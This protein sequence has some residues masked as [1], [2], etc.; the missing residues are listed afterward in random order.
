MDADLKLAVIDSS[1]HTKEI[2]KEL[3]PLVI[4]T[5]NRVLSEQFS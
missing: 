4:E 5:I 3:E 2:Y 1:Q